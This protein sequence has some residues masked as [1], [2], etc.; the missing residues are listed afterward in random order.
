MDMSLTQVG[1][2]IGPS[3][4]WDGTR[5]ELER[6]F[7]GFFEGSGMENLDGSG[8]ELAGNFDGTGENF[9]NFLG[10]NQN[11]NHLAT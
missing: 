10:K 5:Q 9:A 11:G 8:L 6:N 1:C 7:V 3:K 2:R 4:I